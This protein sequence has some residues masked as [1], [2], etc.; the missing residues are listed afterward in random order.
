MRLW[1]TGYRSFELGV[2]NDKDPKVKVIKKVLKEHFEQKFNEGLEWIITGGQLGIEQ[3]ALEQA[4]NMKENYPELKVALMYP[5]KDFGSQWNDEHRAKLKNFEEQVDFCATV[6]NKQ[7]ESPQQLKNFQKFMLE[8]TDQMT[9]I[10]DPEFSGKPDYD[11][12]SAQF[13]A[14]KHS[15]PITLISM[16]DLQNAAMEY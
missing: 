7:Y 14:E 2:F 11:Y 8:H 16:D 10:Y 4:L 1:I 15:Y 3:W 9:M 12:K 5:Y 13:F 6:S